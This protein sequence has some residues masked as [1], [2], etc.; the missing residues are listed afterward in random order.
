V[1]KE[2]STHQGKKKVLKIQWIF[3]ILLSLFVIKN[4]RG[5]RSYVE[6]LLAAGV[7]GQRKV[8]EPLL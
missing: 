6:M 4:F 8:W 5:T 7:Y 3:V 2:P 1:K